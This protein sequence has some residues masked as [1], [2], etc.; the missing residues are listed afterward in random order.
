MKIKVIN[1]IDDPFLKEE[2]ARLATETD[3]FPQ[4]TYHWCATWWHY[5]SGRRILHVVMVLDEDGKALGIA[6]LCIEGHL[7]VRV[8]RS[9]P[10]NYGDYFQIL[11]SKKANE[12]AVF[13]AIYDYIVKYFQWAVVILTPVNDSSSLYNYLC[14]KSIP[15]KH[16]I[17]NIVTNIAYNSWDE[18]LKDLSHNRRRLTRKKMRELEEEHSL[19]VEL[20][21][22]EN[23]YLANFDRIREIIHLRATKDR[24][25]RTD[26]YMRCVRATNGYLFRNK[27]MCLYLIKADNQLITYRLGILHK[28]T[29][30]DW[31]TNYDI[32]WEKYSPGLISIA[33]V[34]RD[35]IRKGFHHL[36]FMAGD[37]DYKLSYSPKHEVRNN[38]MFLI[39][40]NAIRANIV[41]K[42]YMEWRD[43]IRPYYRKTIDWFSDQKSK[44]IKKC[45]LISKHITKRN[46]CD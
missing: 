2:W 17:G 41:V 32:A 44:I 1:N 19:K 35:L 4:S 15:A 37:Y 22:D 45:A 39:S 27:Q 25:D 28:S 26:K 34:I 13:N 31:N 42:Y 20:V 7:W 30:Y 14:N 38:Y 6:P 5:L 12:E 29:Y 18:Y 23:E 46:A 11:V 36:D 8:L 3:V 43:Q 33:Y 21:T 16:L 24:A 9:F 10:V 40:S